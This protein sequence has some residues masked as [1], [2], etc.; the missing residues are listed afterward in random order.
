MAFAGRKVVP[1]ISQA[2]VDKAEEM[3]YAAWGGEDAPTT[4]PD[5]SPI[6]NP[7]TGN[8]ITQ[9][10]QLWASP[11]VAWLRNLRDLALGKI[12]LKQMQMS[13]LTSA[14]V[15][16]ESFVREIAIDAAAMLDQINVALREVLGTEVRM[17]F[18]HF[19][20]IPH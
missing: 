8:Q 7:K 5:G 15:N 19:H 17:T 1:D 12:N 10:E 18:S 11:G 13:A 16:G 20:N 4:N 3:N 6:L 2:L 9:Q 14:N